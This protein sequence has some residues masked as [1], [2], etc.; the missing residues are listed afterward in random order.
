MN[1]I[2]EQKF[3]E[4]KEMWGFNPSLSTLIIKDFFIEK[5]LK[6]ILIPGIGYGRNA[7]IFIQNGIKVS[8][9]EISKTAIDL[10]HKNF[11]ETLK[12][13]HGS[14]SN[15]PFNNELYNGIYAY[16]L[17]HLLA[18]KDR[19]KFIQNC[20]NQLE[21]NGYMVFAT[22][23]KKAKIYGQGTSSEKDRFEVFDGIKFFFYDLKSIKEEFS[24]VGMF[25]V[26]EIEDVFPFYL[27]K[28]KKNIECYE[29]N[30][31]F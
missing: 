16:A 31:E 5:Q 28:C 10:A 13:H 26:T 20:Y 6:N 15:M 12:I 1:E 22:I 24:N 4:N 18:K 14:V 30:K 11:G 23:T 8:G 27:I 21:N 17:I 19:I 7:Q 3:N 2:W 9:I 29:L 25:E